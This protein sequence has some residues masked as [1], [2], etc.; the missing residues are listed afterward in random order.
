[1]PFPVYYNQSIDINYKKKKKKT[2][3][4]KWVETEPLKDYES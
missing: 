2:K 1:M 4:A 3:V